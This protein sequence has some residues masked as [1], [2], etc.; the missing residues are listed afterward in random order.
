MRSDRKITEVN[1]KKSVPD[2]DS[3]IVLVLTLFRCAH[4]HHGCQRV[5]PKDPG[6]RE[7]VLGIEVRLRQCLTWLVF[8]WGGGCS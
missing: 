4:L 1:G 3:D 2:Q 7:E 6:K 8:G 5:E